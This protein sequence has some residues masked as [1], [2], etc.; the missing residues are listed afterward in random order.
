M[1]EGT[2]ET[3]KRRVERQPA[4]MSVE[5]L[6]EMSLEKFH[7]LPADMKESIKEYLD[8]KCKIAKLAYYQ[9]RLR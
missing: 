8:M 1:E 9:R 4:L 3:P 6:K 5:G 7:S 2:R